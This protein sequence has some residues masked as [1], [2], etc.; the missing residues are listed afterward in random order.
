MLC[1][2]ILRIEKRQQ[3][4]LEAIMAFLLVLVFQM[5]QLFHLNTSQCVMWW[6]AATAG[7][8]AV[9]CLVVCDDECCLSD[10][11]TGG[12]GSSHDNQK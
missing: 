2:Q 6:D 10:S 8:W 7:G 11:N 5:G 4:E 3:S 1:G 12:P 9:Y